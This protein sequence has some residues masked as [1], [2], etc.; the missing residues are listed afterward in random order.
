MK[1]EKKDC[2]VEC[3]DCKCGCQKQCR[4]KMGSCT[5]ALYGLGM[6]GALFYFLSGITGF[7]PILVG[8][9]KAIVWPA[10]VVFKILGLL[11]I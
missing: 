7:G 5:E 3:A 6:I 10:F 1:E 8:I 11:G 9:G 4:S 2:C